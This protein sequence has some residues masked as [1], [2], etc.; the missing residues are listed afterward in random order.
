MKYKIYCDG[1]ASNNGYEN[2]IGGWAYIILNERDEIVKENSNFEKF[3]TNNRMELYACY[4]GLYE[5]I[6]EKNDVEKIEVY[7]DSAYLY[8][9]YSQ[10]WYVGWIN[11]NW[12]NSKKQPVANK[13]LWLNLIPYFENENIDFFKVKGHN[14][15]KWNEYVDKLAVAARIDGGD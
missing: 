4:M 6:E 13:Q 2:A 11:K 1:A 15:D 14:N 12:Y 10:K 5:L 3:A 7:T 8:N 9:C